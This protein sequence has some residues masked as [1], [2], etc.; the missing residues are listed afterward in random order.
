MKLAVNN[1]AVVLQRLQKEMA[2]LIEASR[3]GATLRPRKARAV[4][5][6]LRRHCARRQ[7]VMLDALILA[8]NGEGNR[9]LAQIS[10]G[11]DRRTRIAHTYKGDH[12]K[13]KQL[14]P[15]QR[16]PRFCRRLQKELVAVGRK[17]VERRVGRQASRT[18]GQHDQFTSGA[19]ARRSCAASTTFWT[20]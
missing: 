2:R 3:E 5:G 10:N 17:L 8:P 20:P 6:R 14:Q 13:M 4:P 1:V 11:Q 12:E 7:P 18:L 19:Y 16:A 9:I 15:Q